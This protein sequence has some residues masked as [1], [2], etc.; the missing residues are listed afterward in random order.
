[1]KATP[2]TLR[3]C[4]LYSLNQRNARKESGLTLRYQNQAV[5]PRTA[6]QYMRGTF[7]PGRRPAYLARDTGRF[8]L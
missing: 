7:V 4:F 6:L 2:K 8:I 1:M 3:M 5:T